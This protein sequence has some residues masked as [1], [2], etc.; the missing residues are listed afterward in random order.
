MKHRSTAFAVALALVP[1]ACAPADNPEDTEALPES[2]EPTVIAT[3]LNGPMG[4]LVANDGTVWITDSGTGGDEVLRA[5]DSMTGETAE[6][7]YGNTA[8]IVRVDPSGM[9]SD[10]VN[11]PSFILPDAP[12]GAGRLA[13]LGGALYASSSGWMGGTPERWPNNAAVVRVDG[14]TAT[15]VLNTWDTEQG[16]NPD[17]ILVE[18]HPFGLAAGPDG[19]LWIADAAGNVLYRADPQAGSLEVVTAFPPLPGPIPNPSHGGAMEMEPVPTA[20]AFMN[21]ETYVSLLPGAPFPQGAAKVVHVS[22]NGEIHDY[23]TDLSMLTDLQTGP[24]GN[25]YAVSM[26][27]FT[28]A[29]PTPESGSVIRIGEGTTSE[30]VLTGLSLPTAIAFDPEG[31][32]Y[33]TANGLGEP[34]SGQVIKYPNLVG[35]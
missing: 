21:G 14:N 16:E 13:M 22:A 5:P 29:G 11:L 15:E 12:I 17:G 18:A 28:E 1:F 2:T 31:N 26:A 7:P 25:L 3:G 23:A 27:V 10:V 9:Q 24:D 20:V 30:A 32:A 8:R 33:V 34:G 6:L 4:V 19:M 35:M